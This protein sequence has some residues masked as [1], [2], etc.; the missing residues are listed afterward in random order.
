MK[1]L[2]TSGPDQSLLSARRNVASL[3]VQN[4]L[5]VDPDQTA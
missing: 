2:I 3:A 5:S 1:K 4:M